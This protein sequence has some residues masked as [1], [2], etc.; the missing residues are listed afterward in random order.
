MANESIGS[1]QRKQ[2]MFQ[3][4]VFDT[5]KYQ[6]YFNAST[7]EILGKLMDGL[8]PF[9]PDNQPEKLVND[10]AKFKDKLAGPKK[11][12]DAMANA[13]SFFEA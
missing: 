4:Y 11:Q 3:R 6:V 8:W 7:D 13:G 10:F 1:G 2:T 5:Y 12:G 9:H